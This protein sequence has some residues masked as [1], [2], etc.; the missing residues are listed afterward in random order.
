M[1]TVTAAFARHMATAAG[2]QLTHKGSVLQGDTTVYQMEPARDGRVCDLEYY[3][4]IEWI[5]Q[6]AEDQAALVAAYAQ[7]IRPDDLGALG[8]AIKCAP[9]LRQSLQRVERYFR[10]VT[11][12]VRYRLRDDGRLS[13][14][15]IEGLSEDHPALHLRNECALA[16][17]LTG[18]RGMAGSQLTPERLTFRHACSGDAA[19]YEAQFGCPV[20]FGAEQD[21]IVLKSILLELPNR[22]GDEGLSAFLTEHLK[23]QI[24][25]QSDDSQLKSRL[26]ELLAP[27]LSNGVPPASDMA[28]CM[29]M[30]ERTLYRKL[31]EEG[32]TYRDV[33]H[34]AQSRLA[35]DLLSQ[36]KCSIAEIAFLT[37]FSE[38]SSFSR[39]FKR[40]VGKTPAQF[41]QQALPE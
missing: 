35:R 33:L 31:A 40:W 38:Q 22:L 17:F 27:E 20:V 7:A 19:R 11:D 37:G 8:L 13:Y 26:L 10:L 15:T 41:R 28:R 32:L 34:Q 2:L 24:G 18:L 6:G 4:L 29:G 3:A 9:V 23:T 12:T 14:F 30:S 16:S 5:R 36:N 39:A 21:A 25:S 1:P